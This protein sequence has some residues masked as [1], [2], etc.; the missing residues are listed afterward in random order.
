MTES[1][2]TLGDVL[3]RIETRNGHESH[4]SV[5]RNGHLSECVHGGAVPCQWCDWAVV[6]DEVSA[7]VD[8]IEDAHLVL[9]SPITGLTWALAAWSITELP[10][11]VT[12]G[13]VRED[14]REIISALSDKVQRKQNQIFSVLRRESSPGGRIDSSV[15][16]MAALGSIPSIAREPGRWVH[17]LS[18]PVQLTIADLSEQ[19]DIDRL[20]LFC[21]FECEQLLDET[22]CLRT[23]PELTGLGARRQKTL[24]DI[25]DDVTKGSFQELAIAAL[26]IDLTRTIND[27]ADAIEK[28]S[29]MVAIT[30]PPAITPYPKQ[31]R[32]TLWAQC[33]IDWVHTFLDISGCACRHSNGQSPRVGLRAPWFVVAA[34][35]GSNHFGQIPATGPRRDFDVVEDSR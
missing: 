13:D 10:S 9:D 5:L 7:L 33:S 11:T 29:G 1:H 24:E 6:T 8:I 31:L 25:F 4:R 17:H 16:R 21:A 27:L 32:R 12:G 35:A 2:L 28:S 34:L 19:V 14:A 26:M 15:R 3:D 23:V 18:R 22:L 30:F 20:Q